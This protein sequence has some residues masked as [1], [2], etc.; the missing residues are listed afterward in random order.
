MK[1][2]KRRARTLRQWSWIAGAILAG[3]GLAACTGN[4]G[5]PRPPKH[6]SAARARPANPHG[7]VLVIPAS[8]GATPQSSNAATGNGVMVFGQDA[9]RASSASPPRQAPDVV[10]PALPAPPSAT[11]RERRQRRPISMGP[12]PRQTFY[13]SC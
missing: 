6:C 5:T 10:V 8:A 2:E 7:S 12:A 4:A 3:S 1:I 13:R 11:N 9:D